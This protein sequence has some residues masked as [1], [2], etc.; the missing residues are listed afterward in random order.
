MA[1]VRLSELAVKGNCTV[2]RVTGPK[3]IRK[4][5][6]EMGF[7]RGTDIHV[8]KLAPLGDPMELVLKGYHVSLRREES[9]DVHVEVDSPVGKK[10]LRIALC[11][12]PNAGKTCIFNALTGSRQHVGNYAGVTVEKKEG[13][14][15]FGE[16]AVEVVDL[17]GTYSLTAFSQEEIVARD[18]ILHEA[19]DVVVNVV[20]STNLE[21]NLY[22]TTQLIEL[23]CQAVVALNMSDEA[24]HKGI[25]IDTRKMSELLGMPAV[26]TVGTAGIGIQDILREAVAVKEANTPIARRI[27]INYGS[28]VEEEIKKIQTELRKD[29]L[30]KETYSTRWIAVRLLEHDTQVTEEVMAR[31]A[32]KDAIQRQLDA[33]HAHIENILSDESEI[34]MADARY[35]FIKGLLGEA[36]SH[37]AMDRFALSDHM[38][39]VLTNRL[40]GIPILVGFMW[41]MF[42]TTFTLG[43]YPMGWIQSLVRLLSAFVAGAMPSGILKELVVDG[44]ISGI[45]GVVVFLPNILILFF[46]ISLF[47]DTGYMARAAF[48][49][50]RVMHTLG[51]H[52]KSFIPMI[53][54][55]GCNTSAILGSRALENETDRMLT[56]LI[57][58]LISCS[59]RL[60]VYVL[61]AGAFFGRNAGTVIFGIY[62]TGTVLAILV[63]RVLR[64]TLFKGD[65]A[66]FVMELPPYRIPSLKSIVIHM[67]AK[68]SVFLR[69][70]GGIILVASIVI[71][72]STAFPRP[73]LKP[74]EALPADHVAQSYAGRAGK[75]IEPVLRPLGFGWKGGVALVTGV[76][77]KEIVVSTFGVLYQAGEEVDEESEGLRNA[78][79]QDM[80]PLAALSFMLF[81]LIY[82]PCVGALG[83]MYRELGSWRWTLFGA[84]YSL[85]LA[86]IVSFTVYQ[87]G[88]LLGFR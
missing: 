88:S 38:D 15:T 57:N 32:E 19:P 25:L 10:T 59:A 4:R 46:F 66:P 13:Y 72:F 85:A 84:S 1:V 34:I 2:V 49:M 36:Y 27:Q 61:L 83:A 81:T 17:P 22:L 67:W 73:K 50:D 56:I 37:R 69:K 11:G 33:S 18:Y 74:G 14:T 53:M 55:F 64:Q 12:N 5:L 42:Q 51:L 30:L 62:I 7:V 80:T 70:V 52:G 87:G 76:A 40:L 23:G 8:E 79:R 77:A 43:S 6:L 24:R 60:P 47:E 48:I 78:L 29:L 35:G 65:A 68:G 86:W 3:P 39:R 82:I 31:S 54:G 41:I 9:H 16:Y 63:G 58:P 45:G 71:W 26:E 21:R 20:D 28:E 44:I 75:L